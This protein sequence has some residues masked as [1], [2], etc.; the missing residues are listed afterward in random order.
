MHRIYTLGFDVLIPAAI[1]NRLT[2]ANTTDSLAN[3]VLEIANGPTTSRPDEQLIE[4][5]NPA[6]PDVLANT[7]GVTASYF[8]WVQNTTSEC[9]RSRRR[10]SGKH[11]PTFGRSR[12][13]RRRQR[14]AAHTRA[15]ESVL[16]AKECR[17][18]VPRDAA[19][20]PD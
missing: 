15:A 8:E 9:V 1:E 16:Q 4:R 7:G 10:N 6:V 5:R 2:E 11:S 20:L 18:N 17:S 12:R 13:H 14:E 19:D 3:A